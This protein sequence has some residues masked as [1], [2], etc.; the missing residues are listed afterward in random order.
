VKINFARLCCYIAIAFIFAGCAG[1][2]R[3][4]G[5]SIAITGA[6][7]TVAPNQVLNLG[8]VVNG[9]STNS[10]VTWGVVGA[11]TF[12]STTS[13]LVYTAPPTVPTNPTVTVTA[14][15]IAD[16]NVSVSVTFTIATGA[17]SVTITNPITTATAGSDTNIVLNATVANDTGAAGV[18]WQLVTAGTTTACAPGCGTIVTSTTTSF[19][20]LPP[21][22]VPTNASTSIIATS[23]TDPTQ[24]A[25]D[26]FTIQAQAASDLSFLSGPYAFEMSGFDS[27]GNAAT[28]AGS[29]VADGMGGISMGEIDV[30]DHFA[31]ANTK[32]VTGSYT[33][34]PDLRG[35]ITLNQAISPFSDSPMLAFTIDS[36]TNTGTITGLDEELPAVSGVLAAQS[37]AVLSGTPSGNFIFRGS[38]DA[39]ATRFGEVGRFTIGAGGGITGGLI[40]SA[41]IANGNDSQDAT[42][43]G[44]FAIADGT[45]RGQAILDA[46]S[47]SSNYAYYA[48]SPTKIFLI[49]VNPASSTQVL[50]IA[51]AQNLSSLTASSVNGTGVFGLIGG[52]LGTDPVAQFS[53]VAVGQL[54]ISGG[55][56]ASISCDINDAGGPEQCTSSGGAA[57][58][59]L[60]GTVAFDPTTGRGT[61]VIANGFDDGFID[62]LT[63]YLEANGTGVLLDTTSFNGEELAIPEALVGD[64]IPQTSTANLAGQTQA[65]LLI[66]ESD[67]PTAVGTADITGTGLNG[68]FDGTIT[69]LEE[70]VSDQPFAATVSGSDATGR[71]TFQFSTSIGGGVN[72]SGVAYEVS[73]NQY[74]LITGDPNEDSSGL[75]VFTPQTLPA[76]AADAAK[77][78]TKAPPARSMLTGK[79]HKRVRSARGN[80]RPHSQ[81]P[82]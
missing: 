9:D 78:S 36:A 28:V 17:V 2:P 14:T 73:P 57:I 62:S 47:N 52:D 69:P 43:A 32:P 31:I 64:L 54:V 10:G 61:I 65:V 15:S 37:P 42:L 51:R 22:T 40:D 7:T 48:V 30:N 12:T 1:H 81:W 58:A 75:L 8:A 82:N 35:T 60:A 38:S 77:T 21:P 68:L 50:G 5:I 24:S 34:G 11:G 80:G 59:P 67:L 39:E 53:S 13:A 74:F 26:T 41:D 23:I 25:T 66:S 6:V 56:T 45:G 3:R 20:Y 4:R 46:G 19:T 27:D 63:F 33:L 49:E 72:T 70:T 79:P 76:Q 44:S 29:F 16:T 71:S 18:T 55:N